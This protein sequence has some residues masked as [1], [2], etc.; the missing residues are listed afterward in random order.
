M[1]GDT[2][3]EVS[4]RSKVKPIVAPIP[5]LSSSVVQS[6]ETKSPTEA[7]NITELQSLIQKN[8]TD[9]KEMRAIIRKPETTTNDRIILVSA[10]NALD[11]NNNALQNQLSELNRAE[12]IA[13]VNNENRANSVATIRRVDNAAVTPNERALQQLIPIKKID[14]ISIEAK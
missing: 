14:D 4:S 8:D 13:K 7:R 10:V 5:V 6:D 1:S 11:K 3:T 9:L 2:N 12:S